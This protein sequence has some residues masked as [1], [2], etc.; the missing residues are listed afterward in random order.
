MR[1]S[2]SIEICLDI[3]FVF[4]DRVTSLSQCLQ[5]NSLGKRL[6]KKKPIGTDMLPL[7]DHDVIFASSGLNHNR[8]R[9]GFRCSL[10]SRISAARLKASKGLSSTARAIS[11][12]ELKRQSIFSFQ[13]TKSE[14][15]VQFSG[16]GV[17]PVTSQ[18]SIRSKRRMPGNVELSRSKKR[19]R[20]AKDVV[21]NGGMPVVSIAD[22]I[23]QHSMS[24]NH[25]FL[26][27]FLRHHRCTPSMT[28][29][30]ARYVC[31]VCGNHYVEPLNFKHHF[32]REHVNHRYVSGQEL[33]FIHENNHT[34]HGADSSDEA[35]VAISRNVSAVRLSGS[36]HA[37]AKHLPASDIHAA[38]SSSELKA[39]ERSAQSVCNNGWTPFSFSGCDTV[40]DAFRCYFCAILFPSVRKLKRHLDG[41]A[42]CFRGSK[43]FRCSEC[44]STFHCH[45]DYVRHR[46]LHNP[47]AGEISC[48]CYNAV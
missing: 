2:L 23:Q 31:D 40:S 34:E 24:T 22:A 41:N 17:E 5:L 48:R 7:D 1:V 3:L 28:V 30:R 16:R 10:N 44:E 6:R 42:R 39:L 36:S 11:D 21:M 27:R 25:Q 45:D 20:L 15:T 26:F 12:D 37:Q 29:G 9:N 46:A 13:Q 35:T 38:S 32:I 33:D 4:A 47:I 43:Q 19:G 14:V 8:V 18:S